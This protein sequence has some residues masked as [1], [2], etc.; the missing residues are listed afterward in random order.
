MSDNAARRFAPGERV[1]IIDLDKSGHVRTPTYARE[2]IGI[3]DRYCGEFENPEER[4]YGRAA[5]PR[6]P[7]Y[8]VRLMQR[9]LWPGYQGGSA[10]SL[11][12]EIYHHWLRPA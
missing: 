2:K 11:V 5:R 1:R 6:I 3:I 7:L 8:R 9:D 4:A 10:D 12:L